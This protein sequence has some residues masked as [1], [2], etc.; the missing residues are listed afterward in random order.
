MV[1]PSPSQIYIEIGDPPI[2]G[3][4]LSIDP[5]EKLLVPGGV[6]SS[7]R[8]VFVVIVLYVRAPKAS[9]IFDTMI[10]ITPSPT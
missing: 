1:F 8:T 6:I 7:I 5:M 3:G 4:L 2:L 10:S 9:E